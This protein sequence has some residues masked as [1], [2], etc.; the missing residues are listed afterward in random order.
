MP[1]RNYFRDRRFLVAVGGTYDDV[2]YAPPPEVGIC[3]V[4]RL[5]VEDETNAPSTDIRVYV[6]GHGYE[7][8]LMEENSPAAGVLYWDAEE[9]FLM[10]GEALV[11]RFTGATASDVLRL[12]VEGWWEELEEPA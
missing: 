5:G 10:T 8:W 2:E 1:H 6:K 9:T 12:Y 3:H 7:H 11:A 4:T